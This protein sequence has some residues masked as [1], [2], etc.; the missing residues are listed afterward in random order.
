MRVAPLAV[1]TQLYGFVRRVNA[2]DLNRHLAMSGGGGGGGGAVG[3]NAGKMLERK[4]DAVEE[5]LAA[6]LEGIE[7]ALAKL[8]QSS[9]VIG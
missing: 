8:A 5:R 6:R 1:A 2:H 3:G 9:L 7:T 4:I